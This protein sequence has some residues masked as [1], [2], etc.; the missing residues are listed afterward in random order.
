M[1]KN[2]LIITTG[3]TIVSQAT[4][5]ATGAQPALSGED[6]LKSIPGA[7]KFADL[8]VHNFTKLPSTEMTLELMLE[9]ANEIKKALQQ[10]N[11]DGVVITH[12]TDTLEETAYLHDLV[13][14][15]D[16]PVVFT[17]AMR[18]AS[19]LSSDGPMNLLQSIIVASNNQTKGYP[20]VI[21]FNDEIHL[22]RYSMKFHSTSTDAFKSLNAGP[23]GMIRETNVHYFY[24]AFHEQTLEVTKVKSRVEIIKASAGASDFFLQAAIR[25]KIDGIVI[26]GTGAGHVPSSWT[27]TIEK[28][29]EKGIIVVMVPRSPA[30]YP[31]HQTYGIKGG[32]IHLKKLGVLFGFTN[33]QKTRVFL[34]LALSAGW[35]KENINKFFMEK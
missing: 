16:K 26:E 33:G 3:G 9:L 11:V 30:G 12:G 13:L 34:T 1:K 31:L 14:N 10:S 8:R 18:A 23:V 28:A 2:I 15:N 17:G 27:N 24:P 6:L 29:I 19:S 32:E 5:E 25:E 7:N 4:E 22:A 35:D 21:V 20:P